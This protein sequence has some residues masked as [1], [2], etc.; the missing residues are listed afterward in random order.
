MEFDIAG[1]G[2]VVIDHQVILAEYP[3][4]DTKIEIR[5]DRFQVGGPVP[6]ALAVLSRF[7]KRTTFLSHWGDDTFGE[8]IEADFRA[9]QID[10]SGSH[11]RTDLRTGF[12]HAWIDESSGSRTIACA[13]PEQPLT[14]AEI[15]KR[16]LGQ[17]GALH[18]DGWPGEAALHA[19]QIVKRNGGRIF[20]DS[21]SPKPGMEQLIPIVDVLNC[22]RRFLDQFL[23]H[24]DIQQGGRDL[25][26]R[27]PS[28]VTITDGAQG[29][30]LFTKTEQLTQPAFPIS[31]VDTTGA[32]DVFSGALTYALLE[33]WPVDEALKFAAAT[34]ALKCTGLGNREALPSLEE[35]RQLMRA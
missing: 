27:G 2:I 13:R 16:L 10:F 18:L 17:C 11:M 29:A 23:G 7:G 5:D 4:A 9:E 28:L 3:P 34:A 31:A 26:G 24:D 6:T 30:T 8:M 35:V 20:L 25:I 14:V 32:G 21:G 12:A 33:D 1:L 19:A 22:P 15:D